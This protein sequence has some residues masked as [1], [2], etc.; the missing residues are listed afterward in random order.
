MSREFCWTLRSPTESG[1]LHALLFS[2]DAAIKRY[3]AGDEV[4]EAEA[5]SDPTGAS[6][7]EPVLLEKNT[8]KKKSKS[9]KH[10][11]KKRKKKKSLKKTMPV[12]Q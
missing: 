12:L 3:E 1:S 7:A 6:D 2:D 5:L 11:A 4:L 8:R 9:G 10:R